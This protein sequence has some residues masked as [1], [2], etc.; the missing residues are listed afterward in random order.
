MKKTF[1]QALDELESIVKRLEEGD[2]PLE[3]SLELFER[4]V[5]LSRDCRDRLEKAERRIEMLTKDPSGEIR[6][7]PIPL[8]EE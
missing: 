3:E 2:M 7:E 8:D 1:E 6:L 5:R 4:G